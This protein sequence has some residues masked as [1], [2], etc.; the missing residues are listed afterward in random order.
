MKT[1]IYKSG[2][3]ALFA[4][5]LLTSCDPEIDS[6]D[7]TSGN[8]DFETYVALG[9]SLTA[10][11][12]DGALYLEGQQSSYPAIL[13]QQFALVGGDQSFTQ[14]LMPAGKSI[15]SP[16]PNAQG[17]FEVPQRRIL[18]IAPDCK[19]VPGLSP[20]E[21]GT[22]GAFPQAFFETAPTV[23]GP[24]NN[25]GVPGAKSIHL[26]APGYGNPAG[27]ANG[28]ANPFFVRFASSAGTSVLADALA[29]N[30]TFFTL[31]IGNNDVL[32]Y[33][34]A[35]GV[36]VAGEKDY[37]TDKT[38]FAGAINLLAT[39]LTAG[40][41]KGAMGNI[42]DIT[43]IP[44]FT[45][46]PYNG[47]VLD[48]TQA[49]Q[50]TAAYG[51]AVT[52]Q[53]G[54][55]PFIIREDGVTRP[56]KSTEYILLTIPQNDI[57]CKGLGSITPIDDKYVISETELATIRDYTSSYN[58][59][60]ASV[61]QSKGLALADFNSYMNRAAAGFTLNGVTYSS[62]FVSGNIFSLDGIHFTQRGA[63]LVA[64]EFISVINKTYNARVPKVDETQYSTVIFP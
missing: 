50:L 54:Q 46:V 61:A 27:L 29:Q 14:P 48:A 57:K 4:G 28:T 24:Y 49:A 51:G 19:N 62:T 56:I 3:L 1:F 26:L 41:A 17:Q 59:S 33:A 7:P 25:L 60:I 30:P 47:L 12:T 11:F 42:P 31:W 34:L 32:G 40:G 6:P 16:R 58:A 39:Q 38:Q 10:G 22:P 21:A 9:N 45:T 53:A 13:A 35:G 20:V 52:F 36:P 18:A 55:N 15:G 8:A 2:M 63:A 37:P 5:V 23:Q 43:K 44:F 64:N